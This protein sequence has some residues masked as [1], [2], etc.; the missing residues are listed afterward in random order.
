MRAN[1]PKS[2][3]PRKAFPPRRVERKKALFPGNKHGGKQLELFLV[4]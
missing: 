2:S 3:L 1:D 4:D